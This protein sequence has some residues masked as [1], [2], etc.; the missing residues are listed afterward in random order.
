M[1]GQSF[2]NNDVKSLMFHGLHFFTTSGLV[3]KKANMNLLM[4]HFLHQDKLY[5]FFKIL[6]TD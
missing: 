2:Y 6:M 5:M 4:I 1:L 3:G